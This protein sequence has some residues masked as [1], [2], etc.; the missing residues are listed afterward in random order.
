M[1]RGPAGAAAVSPVPVTGLSSHGAG[2]IVGFMPGRGRPQ[3]VAAT[4]ILESIL[5][6]RRSIE[7]VQPKVASGEVEPTEALERI[8]QGLIE[9]TV[10]VEP[11]LEDYRT[12]RGG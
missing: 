6:L 5:N 12:R 8:L 9:L 10:A 1:F 2:G 3:P 4:E 7:T 11:L